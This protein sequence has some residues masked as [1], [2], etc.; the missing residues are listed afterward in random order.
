MFQRRLFFFVISVLAFAFKAQ[1]A[2]PIPNGMTS[3]DRQNATEILGFGTGYKILGDPYPLGG[4]SGYE[5]G[6]SYEFLNTSE[7]S[8]L[9]AKSQE[10]A[11]TS[12]FVFS[13]SKGLY[14][15]IDFSLQFSP[16]GQSERF[17]GFG[18]AVRWG[19]AEMSSQP[20][21]FSLQASA[22][23]A[24]FQEKI[25]TTTQSLDLLSGYTSEMWTLYGGFGFIRT[26][27][28]FIGGPQ[29][30]TDDQKTATETVSGV[31][32]FG[33][34]SVKLS[35]YFLALQANHID[36]SNY[37]VKIGARF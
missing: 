32:Y 4:Y 29:G 21:H 2:L 31:Q 28:V 16:L 33:G 25:N 3:L 6:L 12:Y 34:L 20:V 5:L 11:T 13:L 19:F 9:G 26:S 8:Q 14:Y 17:S 18:G 37:S 24:S 36:Q 27:G 30:I 15:G 1:A 23:S 35:D 7:I 10:Q 22:N